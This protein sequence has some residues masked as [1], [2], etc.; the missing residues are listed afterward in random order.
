MPTAPVQ[1]TTTVFPT[2]T[3][4]DYHHPGDQSTTPASGIY[5]ETRGFPLKEHVY[6]TIFSFVED[7]GEDMVGSSSADDKEDAER[8]SESHVVSVQGPA[9]PEAFSE[10][11]SATTKY[12]LQNVPSSAATNVGESSSR[13]PE[14]STTTAMFIEPSNSSASPSVADVVL[15]EEDSSSEERHILP[16]LAYNDTRLS[17]DTTLPMARAATQPPGSS[18]T[19]DIPLDASAAQSSTQVAFEREDYESRIPVVT[20]ESETAL[21]E[22]L[23]SHAQGSAVNDTEATDPPRYKDTA[24]L[25][26]EYDQV[27]SSTFSTSIADI[28]TSTPE[29]TTNMDLAEHE[30]FHSSSGNKNAA[31]D[32]YTNIHNPLEFSTAAASALLKNTTAT[33]R[34][35]EEERQTVTYASNITEEEQLTT[36]PSTVVDDAKVEEA[37]PLLTSVLEVKAREDY[38]VAS[39]LLSLNEGSLMPKVTKH[40]GKHVKK[41]V[42][43][44][45]VY[46]INE[47]ATKASNKKGGP[48]IKIIQNFDIFIYPTA[49]ITKSTTFLSKT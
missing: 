16:V 22:N 38:A 36:V 19:T 28:L 8:T 10:E 25:S 17:Q 11:A 34:V 5:Q 45:F 26:E 43:T 3:A 29:R 23:L 41:T 13:T 4:T 9:T 44:S 37:P 46:N 2:P 18:F 39:Q 6:A 48:G 12:V 1:F 21:T 33:T 35:Q 32:G 31:D 7:I 20:T 14:A 30:V 49:N 15:A 42:P 40:K 24:V 27:S 47:G